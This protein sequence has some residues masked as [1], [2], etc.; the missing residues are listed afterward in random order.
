MFG[1]EP[2][3]WI[4]EG[5]LVASVYPPD[6]KYLEFMME[7]GVRSA[8]NMDIRPWPREWNDIDIDYLHLPVADMTYPSEAQV[9]EGLNF[10]DKGLK[11]GAV[12]IH[13]IAGLGRTGTMMALYLVHKGTDPE[14]AIERVRKRRKGSIQTLAQERVIYLRAKVNG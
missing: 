6:R 9:R 1:T 12:L 13:C 7:E 5:R 4:E 2:F 8:I 10:I 14:R 3:S 11:K